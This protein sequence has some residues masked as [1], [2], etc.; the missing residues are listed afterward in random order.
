[1]TGLLFALGAIIL[2]ITRAGASASIAKPNIN[3][4]LL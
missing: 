4:M 2:D 3:N 1:L